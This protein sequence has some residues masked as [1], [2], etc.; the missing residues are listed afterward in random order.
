MPASNDCSGK[1]LKIHFIDSTT[2]TESWCLYEI[3]K[4][5]R[6]IFH[7]APRQL[8]KWEGKEQTKEIDYW[9]IFP[10]S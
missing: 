4:V 10:Q 3:S 9:A 5:K 8:E 1:S 2:A 6:G 7:C